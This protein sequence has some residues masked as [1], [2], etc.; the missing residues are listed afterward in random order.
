LVRQR[1]IGHGWIKAW[2]RA[3]PHC[4]A[5]ALPMVLMAVWRGGEHVSGQTADWF[6]WGAK[7]AWFIMMLRDRWMAFDIASVGILCFVL[8]LG[9]RNPNLRYSRNLTLSALFLL[10]VYLLLPRIVFGSAYADMRLAPYMMGIALIAI[11][12]KPGISIRGASLLAL[13]G[14]AFFGVRIAATTVSFYLYDQSW[15]RELA[16][17]DHVPVGATMVSF[18]GKSCRNVW[19]G[20]RFEHL[21]GFALERRLAFSN[22]QWSMPGAQLL[23]VRYRAAEG[24]ARDPSEIVTRSQCPHEFWRPIDE[25][26][27]TF[28]RDAFDY[29][30]LVQP[31]PYDPALTR[32]LTPIWRSGTSVLFRIDDRRP[33]AT[34]KRSS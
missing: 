2:V 16:A 34:I 22:D 33:P 26:L 15:K 24:F 17:L 6:N 18:V 10:A 1:D 32:G 3:I 27:A 20:P 9:V 7:T 4:L 5:L 23:I 29:V 13:A 28:P 19:Y 25:A 8:F 31:P 12:P 11:R 30:W 14:L 21:P